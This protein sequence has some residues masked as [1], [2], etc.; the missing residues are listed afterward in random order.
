MKKQLCIILA[1]LVLAALG[2]CRHAEEPDVVIDTPVPAATCAPADSA[3]TDGPAL[4]EPTETP[5]AEPATPEPTETPTAEPTAAPICPTPEPGS[6]DAPAV[7]SSP[8]AD[9]LAGLTPED[10]AAVMRYQT[11]LL[12]T[13]VLDRMPETPSHPVAEPRFRQGADGIWR[14]SEKGDGK[15]VIMMTGD[16]MCQSRQIEAG[17]TGNGYDF[18]GSFDYVRPVFAEADFVIGNLEGTACARTPY[19]SE[20]VKIEY[21]PNLNF[22][23]SFIEAV[24]DAGYDMVVNA[25]NHC[26]DAGVRGVFDTLSHL[27]EY[28]LM[29]TGTFRSA[30]EPRFTI[31]EVDGIRVGVLSYASIIELDGLVVKEDHIY[32]AFN[33]KERHFTQEGVDTLLNVYHKDKA[34]RDIRAARA[35]GAEFVIVYIHWGL[36]YQNVP[37]VTQTVMAQEIADAGADYIIGSHSHALQPYD[38]VTSADGRKVPVIYGMGNFLSHQRTTVTKD[39]II[40]RVTLERNGSGAVY[41]SDEG[42]IPARVFTTFMG[43]DYVVV[44]VVKPYSQGAESAYFAPAYQ[45]ITK[46]MGKKIKVLGTL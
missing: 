41:V 13:A 6:S 22:P 21:R 4:P 9:P 15:A 31:A 24:R 8:N 16:V 40:L 33:E 19:M 5:T 28:R 37:D 10:R 7:T 29:H 1:L 20:V 26:C 32:S 12:D 42:Y 17:R 3:A 14:S 34:E 39:T 30:D 45:R 46:I 43:G 35:A 23:A 38:R 36:E 18:S 25:N 11:S 44:P 2:G 27:D